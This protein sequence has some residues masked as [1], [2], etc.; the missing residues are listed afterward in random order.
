MLGSGQRCGST[1]VQRL[2]TSH[3]DVLI[4]GEQRGSLLEL[5][6]ASRTLREWNEVHGAAAR[7][8]FARGGHQAFIA[9]LL[10][11]PSTVDEAARAYL[12]TLFAAP[13]AAEGAGIW[14]F[15]E[16]RL[17]LEFAEWMRELFPE[18]RVVHVT[19]DPRD[20][21]SSL[22]WWERSEEHVWARHYTEIAL[23]A[24]VTVNESFVEAADR[25]PW[26]QS[27]RYE[28]V[29][30]DPESFVHALAELTELDPAALRRSVF[31]RR[32]AGF[33]DERRDLVPFERLPADVRGLVDDRVRAVAAR[34]GYVL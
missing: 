25:L 9:N 34:Y 13:A 26:L 22:E 10:P 32:I 33:S 2:L 19:R 14:G 18:T 8:A 24:W 16:V 6:R 4:W 15:K 30:A 3:P 11:E 28:D 21:L 1:L 7:G 27:W 12:R 5:L 23:N 29:V 17:G 31:G 20:V